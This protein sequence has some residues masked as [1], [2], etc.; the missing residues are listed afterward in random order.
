MRVLN[1]VLTLVLILLAMPA[2]MAVAFGWAEVQANTDWQ[3][4]LDAGDL[5]GGAGTD[6]STNI[7]SAA[8]EQQISIRGLFGGP[9]GNWAVSVERTDDANWNS[10]IDVYVKRT[11]G[12]TG[13]GSISGGLNYQEITSTSNQFFTGTGT[14]SGIPLQFMT[15]GGFAGLG[16]P[17]A[18]YTT[19]VTYTFAD[20]L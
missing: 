10:L 14:L 8:A 19:T 3:L 2:A 7:E 9:N 15:N 12:G 20:N 5:T 13:T 6:L 11:G 18:T 4:T 17:A 1:K 16:L